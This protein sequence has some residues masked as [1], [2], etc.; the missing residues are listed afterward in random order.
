[1]LAELGVCVKTP[2]NNGATP[3]LVAAE[4]GHVEVVRLLAE[5]GACVKTP[6]NDGYT[7]F[8]AAAQEGHAEVV[9]SLAELG[10]CVKTPQNDGATQGG[11]TKEKVGPHEGNPRYQ[12]RQKS[13]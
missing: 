9:R 5:L 8:I 13:H 3:V 12:K 10:A 2:D 6:D 11:G 7:P 4:Q 1:M